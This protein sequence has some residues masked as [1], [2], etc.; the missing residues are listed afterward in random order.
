MF[1]YIYGRSVFLN[2][3]MRIFEYENI[4]YIRCNENAYKLH[5]ID[6]RYDL[7]TELILQYK[8][9]KICRVHKISYFSDLI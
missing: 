4:L 6:N 2:C 7:E 3:E 5:Y 1:I 9:I 8:I